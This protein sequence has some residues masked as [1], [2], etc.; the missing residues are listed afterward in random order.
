[1][2]GK[3]YYWKVLAKNI[4]DD[5]LWC[6]EMNVLTITSDARCSVQEPIM[7]SGTFILHTNFP[8]PFNPETTIQFDMPTSGLV[9]ISIYDISGR[10][11]KMLMYESRAAG[12]YSVKWDGRDSAGNSAPSGMY[13][14]RMEVRSS[15]GRRFS[16]SVKMGLVR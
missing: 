13:V 9:K 8:N 7:S 3:T 12:S 14:C 15:N 1:M 5:S 11:V 2:P 6:S 4:P 10:L 16:K